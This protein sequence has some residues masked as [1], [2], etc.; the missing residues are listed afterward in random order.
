MEIRGRI[1]SI[2]IVRREGKKAE[3]GSRAEVVVVAP[4]PVI[5]SHPPIVPYEVVQARHFKNLIRCVVELI[6]SRVCVENEY[7]LRCNVTEVCADRAAQR[8]DALPSHRDKC[9]EW[10]ARSIVEEGPTTRCL[11]GLN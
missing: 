9:N 2:S 8:V 3:L 7:N 11:S 1:Q 5:A 6:V 4:R 10:E